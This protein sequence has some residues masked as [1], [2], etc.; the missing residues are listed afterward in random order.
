MSVSNTI[1]RTIY[2]TNTDFR[3]VREGFFTTS[4][5]RTVTVATDGAGLIPSMSD[6][7]SHA[8]TFAYNALVP[9]SDTQ[10]PILYQNLYRVFTADNTSQANVE[11]TYDT[12]GHVMSARDAVAIQGGGRA[13][14]NFYIAN[15]GSGERADPT[16]QSYLVYYDTLGRPAR[17]VDEYHRFTD[18]VFDG[19]GHVTDTLYPEGD[20]E[21]FEY[22]TH[23]NTTEYRQIAKPGCAHPAPAAGRR[24][25]RHRGQRRLEPDLEQAGVDHRRARMHDRVRLLR[26]GRRQI[27]DAVRNA[28]RSGRRG[29]A[30]AAG[31]YLHVQ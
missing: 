25:R 9:R 15:G 12:L 8:T 1:G 20:S 27:A 10:R 31:L 26:L 23:N 3:G 6:P 5:S 2:F 28:V 22:D 21:H 16:G 7:M 13:P 24:M 29:A 14:Y 30:G 17:Y 4:P 19:R 11:Y 18:A